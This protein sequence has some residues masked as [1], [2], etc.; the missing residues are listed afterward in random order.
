MQV[1]TDQS[2]PCLSRTEKREARRE[3]KAQTAAQ[4][5]KAI[6]AELL[7]RLQAGTYGDIYNFP[8]KQYEAVL[9]KAE[10][11]TLPRY[12]LHSSA[13]SY[14]GYVQRQHPFGYLSASYLLQPQSGQSARLHRVVEVHVGQG[15]TA[16]IILFIVC[17]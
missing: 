5:E 17:M 16:P 15:L 14:S 1:A 4:L 12:N 11:R 3:A 13:L 7:K 2:A 9:D 8:T 6:E 10:A